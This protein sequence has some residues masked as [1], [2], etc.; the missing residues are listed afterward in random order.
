MVDNVK[1]MN[2]TKLVMDALFRYIDVNDIT[3]FVYRVK[4]FPLMNM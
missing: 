3:F 4:D 1:V 2:Q